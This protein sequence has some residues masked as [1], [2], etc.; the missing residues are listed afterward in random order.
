MYLLGSGSA[1]QGRR[2]RIVKEWLTATYV[3]QR[4]P[5]RVACRPIALVHMEIAE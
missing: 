5:K 3:L 4:V 1:S 2:K